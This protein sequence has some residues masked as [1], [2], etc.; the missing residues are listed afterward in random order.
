[1]HTI[2]VEEAIAR[3]DAE[4]ACVAAH[5]SESITLFII[6]SNLKPQLAISVAAVT[7]IVVASGR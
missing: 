1:M 5:S 4:M 3:G 6:V 7:A 2:G